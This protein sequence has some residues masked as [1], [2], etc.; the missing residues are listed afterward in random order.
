MNS[1]AVP[2]GYA[3]STDF[4]VSFGPADI[5]RVIVGAALLALAFFLRRTLPTWARWSLLTAGAALIVWGV[6][7]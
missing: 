1:P 7:L 2:T 3:S 4:I 5:A 6:L